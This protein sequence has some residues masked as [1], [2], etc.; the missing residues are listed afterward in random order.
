MIERCRKPA[1]GGMT[2]TAVAPE[3]TTMRVLGRVACIAAGGS[4]FKNI[5]TVAPG[6]IN[7]CVFTGQ[8]KTGH[9]MIESC[10]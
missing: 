1:A 7:V 3:L 4:A 10:R 2:G 9:V 8:L 6:T 5:I